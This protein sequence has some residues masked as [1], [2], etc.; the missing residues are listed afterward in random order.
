MGGFDLAAKANLQYSQGRND[1]SHD[2]L[3]L[4]G[5]LPNK[6]DHV[7]GRPKR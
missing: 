2:M 7:R 1:Y 3:F 4:I 6:E 5:M